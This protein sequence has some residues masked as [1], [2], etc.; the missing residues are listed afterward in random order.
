MDQSCR[1]VVP[2]DNSIHF[3]ELAIAL[4]S[5]DDAPHMHLSSYPF[6]TLDLFQ[7]PKTGNTATRG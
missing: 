3:D 4:S 2:L 1:V 6:K 5:R 7:G